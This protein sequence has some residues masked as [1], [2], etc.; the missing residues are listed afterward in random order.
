MLDVRLP[1]V[2][3]FL[4][5]DDGWDELVNLCGVL[6]DQWKDLI[7]LRRQPLSPLNVSGRYE[8]PTEMSETSRSSIIVVHDRVELGPGLSL[9]RSSFTR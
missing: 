7:D 4:A 9:A 2:E 5:L 1:L 3:P 8:A 6:V